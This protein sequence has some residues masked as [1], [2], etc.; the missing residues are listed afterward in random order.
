MWMEATLRSTG[1]WILVISMACCAAGYSQAEEPTEVPVWLIDPGFTPGYNAPSDEDIFDQRLLPEDLMKDRNYIAA[2]VNFV[3][4][5][6]MKKYRS[7]DDSSTLPPAP[8]APFNLQ[9]QEP[10]SYGLRLSSDK[11]ML[12]AKYRF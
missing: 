2:T 7:P 11:L 12:K 9:S 3:L 10:S 8:N 1:H 6:A 4:H 5:Q